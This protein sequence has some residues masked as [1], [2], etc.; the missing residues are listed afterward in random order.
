MEPISLGIGLVGL[1]LQLFGGSKSSSD[2]KYYAGQI[3]DVNQGIAKNEIAISNQK[4]QQMQ[5]EARR[6]QLE[7]VRNAQRQRAAGV[8]A[9]TNQ[10]AQFGSG[11]QGGEAQNTDQAL[12][13]LQGINQNLAF[14]NTIF[15]INNDITNQKMQLNNL[16]TQ[17][18]QAS[19]TDASISSIGGALVK[20]GPMIG[21]LY[22]D[23]KAGNL[24]S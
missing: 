21:G 11:L 24:F 1:G 5:I 3:N 8:N 17:Y 14:G 9:A 6:M 19:A 4:Q 16:Q 7:T 22:K 18:Q 13:N 10:G 15:G 23:A 12:F 20:S 2:S